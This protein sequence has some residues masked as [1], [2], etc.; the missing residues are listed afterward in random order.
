[1]PPRPITQPTL[2]ESGLWTLDLDLLD[3][4]VRVESEDEA[5]LRGLSACFQRDSHESAGARESSLEV[6]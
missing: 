6:G 2:R 5:F 3:L 4:P 1:M